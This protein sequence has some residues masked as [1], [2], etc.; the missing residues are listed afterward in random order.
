MTLA[1]TLFSIFQYIKSE[2]YYTTH[3]RLLFKPEGKELINI[4][5]QTYAYSGNRANVFNT[6]LEL[7]KSNTVL[8]LVADNLGNRVRPL[9]IQRFLTIQQGQTNKEKNDIIE[10]SYMNSNPELARD[11]LNELCKTYIDY[12]LEVNAQEITR[13]SISSRSR[14]TSSKRNLT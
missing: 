4:G 12:R 13:Y 3:A 5:D 1:L 14:S 2:K 6:H 7:L 8:N 11:V 10:L 9:Q